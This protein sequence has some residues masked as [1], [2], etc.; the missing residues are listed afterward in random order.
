MMV[1]VV[2]IV[3]VAVVAVQ[4][5]LI[6]VKNLASNPTQQMSYL[7]VTGIGVFASPARSN[8]SWPFDLISLKSC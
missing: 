7:Q 4:A 2:V 8:S 1:I 6:K 3:V 5:R